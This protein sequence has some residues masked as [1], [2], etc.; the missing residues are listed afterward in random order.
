[1]RLFANIETPTLVAIAVLAVTADLVLVGFAAHA[2]NDD[3]VLNAPIPNALPPIALLTGMAQT[4]ATVDGVKLS[5][6]EHDGKI[7][8]V[9]ANIGTDD[10]ELDLNV[11]VKQTSGSPMSRMGPVSMVVAEETWVAAVSPHTSRTKVFDVAAPAKE[12][13]VLRATTRMDFAFS[14]TEFVLTRGDEY[15]AT[16]RMGS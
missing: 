14:T 1:M 3:M 6:E 5:L 2:E 7:A 10:S 4:E 15:V 12:K 13:P 8:L 16:L 11:T 9:A